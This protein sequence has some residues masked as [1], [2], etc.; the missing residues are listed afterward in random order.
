MRTDHRTI[1]S[2]RA[3]SKLKWRKIRYDR[4]YFG[5][6]WRTGLHGHAECLFRIWVAKLLFQNSYFICRNRASFPRRLP[7]ATDAFKSICA[8]SPTLR[9]FVH[10]RLD[11][12][13]CCGCGFPARLDVSTTKTLSWTGATRMGAQ[14]EEPVPCTTMSIPSA[15]FVRPPP[16]GGG[17][18]G[19]GGGWLGGLAAYPAGV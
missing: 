8:R 16:G 5:I 6:K 17:L 13:A 2:T 12:N 14:R 4:R 15:C 11:L 7:T 10:A 19:G 9:R 18:A 1:E 3:R